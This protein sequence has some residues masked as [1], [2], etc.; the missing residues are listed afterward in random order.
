[1]PVCVLSFCLFISL[2]PLAK[3]P[4]SR[5]TVAVA[6]AAVAV[7]AVAVVVVVVVVV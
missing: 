2:P 5:E 4:P 7:A 6:V 3:R 1:M